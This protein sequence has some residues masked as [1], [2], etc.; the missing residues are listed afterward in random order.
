MV[1]GPVLVDSR[2]PA[3]VYE[4]GRH[5]TYYFASNDVAWELLSASPETRE[6]RKGGARRWTIDV[7]GRRVEDAVWS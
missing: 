3:L 6:S 5:P 1:D 2:S 7:N 4:T